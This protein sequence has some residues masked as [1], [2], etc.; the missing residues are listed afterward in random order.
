MAEAVDDVMRAALREARTIAIVG[1]SDK[2]DRPV[3]GVTQFLAGKG[4]RCIPVNPRLAGQT[5]VGATVYASLL[6]IPEPVDMVD[7]FVNAERVGPLVDDAIAI[8]AKTVWMQ[9]GVV[10]EAA[11]ES[12]R[13][14][15]LRVV[16]DHCP[17]REWSRL[18]L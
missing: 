18:G 1:A 17:A 13:A 5:V 2:P 7:L 10:N 4:F 6:D 3:Y 14:A 16:M 8:G 15:G 12:A 9:L 11:A